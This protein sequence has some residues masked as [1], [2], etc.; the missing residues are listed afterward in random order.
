MHTEGH[1]REERKDLSPRTVW[2]VVSW[3]SG[4]AWP[5]R[6]PVS[7]LEELG[8]GAKSEMRAAFSERAMAPHRAMGGRMEPSRLGCFF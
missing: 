1:K 6:D 3:G 7:G 8:F 4:S 5:R 2:A